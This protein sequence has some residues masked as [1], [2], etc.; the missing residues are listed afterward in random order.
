MKKAGSRARRVER[1]LPPAW[2]RGSGFSVE[3][4]GHQMVA[5]ENCSFEKKLVGNNASLLTK[6]GALRILKIWPQTELFQGKSKLTNRLCRVCQLTI[7]LF[8]YPRFLY[9]LGDFQLYFESES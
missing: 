5:G 1:V 4:R 2:S 3:A 7:R 6:Q 9:F 8:I